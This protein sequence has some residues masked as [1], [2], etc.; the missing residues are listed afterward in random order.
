MKEGLY[1]CFPQLGVP[2]WGSD[3]KDYSIWGSILR[4][5]YF[6]KLPYSLC[7][8]YLGIMEKKMETSILS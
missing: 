8:D 5:L 3:N 4:S 1:G 7:R 6:G 2:F